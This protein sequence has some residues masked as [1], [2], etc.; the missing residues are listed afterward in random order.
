M[1]AE[2]P[3]LFDADGLAADLELTVG[4][5][6]HVRPARVGFL[7]G[8]LAIWIYDG[9]PSEAQK[10]RLKDQARAFLEGVTR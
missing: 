3:G 8:M 4:D 10:E 7:A 9:K 6:P 2:Q 1:A 5:A